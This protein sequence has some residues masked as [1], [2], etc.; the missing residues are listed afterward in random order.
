MYVEIL[1]AQCND[2]VKLD[3]NFPFMGGKI[4]YCVSKLSCSQGSLPPPHLRKILIGASCI[5][6]DLKIN[7]SRSYIDIPNVHLISFRYNVL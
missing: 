1:T 3:A 7:H 6:V 5:T 4:D 2:E